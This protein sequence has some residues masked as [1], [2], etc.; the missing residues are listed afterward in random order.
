[1]HARALCF[2]E[3]GLGLGCGGAKFMADKIAEAESVSAAAHGESRFTLLESEYGPPPKGSKTINRAGWRR[4]MP[5]KKVV[6]N[7]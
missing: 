7:I 4:R 6:G 2:A 5:G 1:M 3:V